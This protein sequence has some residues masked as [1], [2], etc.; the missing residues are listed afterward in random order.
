MKETSTINSI[1][2]EIRHRLE[3]VYSDPLL[4]EQYAW[5][6]VETITGKDKATLLLHPD[7]ILTPE[8]HHTLEQW[9]YKMIKEHEPIQYLIGSVPFGNVEIIVK[10]PTLIPRPETEEWTIK[11]IDQL[12][13]LTNSK[14]TILDLCCGTGCIAI[15]IAKALPR[16]HIIAADIAPH[17]VELSK[18]NALHNNTPNVTVLQSDLFASMPSNMKFDLI[19]SNPPYINPTDWASLDESVTAWEDRQALIA[20]DH[21]LA[22]IE[23][24]VMQAPNYL[25]PTSE[26]LAENI[27]QLMLE[28]DYN[29][30]NAVRALMESTY[31]THVTI[32]KDLEGKDRVASGSLK[33][34]AIAID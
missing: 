21:G 16:A 13:K 24:I 27:P 18:K 31:Y 7:N 19:V 1:I 3:A 28:I 32:H 23:K 4:C 22:I 12:K 9:L 15:A 30:G 17:A 26:C 25:H 11:L 33:D 5:W 8:Q 20:D 10:S 2:A 34:V 14:L 6:T 29:Q